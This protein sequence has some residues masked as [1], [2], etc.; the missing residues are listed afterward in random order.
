MGTSISAGNS[1]K[2][3]AGEDENEL[4]ESDSE[5][6]VD[7]I[8]VIIGKANLPTEPSPS[9]SGERIK[10]SANRPSETDTIKMEN[11]ESNRPTESEIEP[12]K[13]KMKR[14]NICGA[15]RNRR[16]KAKQ[17]LMEPEQQTADTPSNGMNKKNR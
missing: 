11:V 8:T 10:G 17:A 16:L 4:L 9:H 15:E 7:N 12:K 3:G 2:D 13:G 1:K 6:Y 14:K 5:D